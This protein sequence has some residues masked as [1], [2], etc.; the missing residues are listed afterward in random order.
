MSEEQTVTTSSNPTQPETVSSELSNITHLAESD[1]AALAERIRPVIADEI[2]KALPQL[3]Q[4]VQPLLDSL[5]QALLSQV[6]QHHSGI[7]SSIENLFHK[8]TE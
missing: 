8:P 4:Q 2:N 7:I 5:K 6:E 1:L 3:Q